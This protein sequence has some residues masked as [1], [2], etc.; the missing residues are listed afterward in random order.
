MRRRVVELEALLAD[1]RSQR[2][3]ESSGP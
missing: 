2:L 1:R 3:H